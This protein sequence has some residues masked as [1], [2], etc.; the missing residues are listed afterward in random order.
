MVQDGPPFDTV[1]FPAAGA[2]DHVGYLAHHANRA[3]HGEGL[4]SELPA[5]PDGASEYV[6]RLWDPAGTDYV[7]G[8]AGTALEYR[9]RWSGGF[10][11]W[12][13]TPLTARILS[14]DDV[15]IHVHAAR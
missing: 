15:V 1:G 2:Q 4:A 6:A 14:A 5:V 7:K 9:F 3:C 11:D 8:D 12:C 13:Q 10:F